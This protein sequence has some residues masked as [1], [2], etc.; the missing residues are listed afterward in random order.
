MDNYPTLSQEPETKS[1]GHAFVGDVVHRAE[2]QSGALLTR[3]YFTDVPI[4]WGIQYTALS[5]TD[6]QILEQWEKDTI[7]FGGTSFSWANPKDGN[8]YEG[9]LAA[10][11]VY[12]INSQSSGK[13]SENVWTITF[14]IITLRIL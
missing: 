5:D 10:P 12:K 9:I 7:G 13:I 14:E 1:F 8:T 4:Q 6:K 11:I 3:P 2:F